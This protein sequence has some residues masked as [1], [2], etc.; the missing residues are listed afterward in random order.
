M[1]K[2]RRLGELQLAI[3]RV[4]WTQEASVADVRDALRPERDV[5]TT[6]V[7]TVL[8]RLEQQGVVAR[9]SKDGVYVYRA[10]ATERE[11]RRN[12][13]GDIVERLFHGDANALVHHLVREEE[14]DQE[15]LARFRIL[16]EEGEGGA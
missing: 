10:L 12:M 7:A 15:E 4:L 11:V 6:T 8:S 13:V 2:T 16:L 5:A 3:M 14:V 9:S 1:G